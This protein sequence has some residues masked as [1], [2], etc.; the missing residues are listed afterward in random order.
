[1]HARKTDD[2]EDDRPARR[3]ERSDERYEREDVRRGRVAK[4]AHR[5]VERS[6]RAAVH[7]QADVGDAGA[8]HH[9]HDEEDRHHER[10]QKLHRGLAH[11]AERARA[12]RGA[13]GAERREERAERAEG[14]VKRRC[15]E[16]RERRQDHPERY[17]A[18]ERLGGRDAIERLHR[19]E[20]EA[21]D[22][23]KET[24]DF[25]PARRVFPRDE[26]PVVRA[27][28]A[29]ASV[30]GL[31]ARREPR[32]QRRALPRAGRWTLRHRSSP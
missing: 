10:E 6:V 7:H 14:G 19:L 23:E 22:G 30:G 24:F 17:R 18:T 13:R 12:R 20:Q 1:M 3:G 32:R 2:V 28:E 9:E 29:I 11:G 27:R 8:D 4:D 31:V 15:R 16:L 5:L 21:A 25:A 26:L